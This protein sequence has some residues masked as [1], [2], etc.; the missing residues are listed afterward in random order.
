LSIIKLN[1][2]STSISF[3][4]ILMA[5]STYFKPD[6]NKDEK[7]VPSGKVYRQLFEAQVQLGKAYDKVKDKLVQQNPQIKVKRD[8][9]P[10]VKENSSLRG[11]GFLTNDAR[12]WINKLENDPY[13]NNPVYQK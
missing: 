4:L 5:T 8:G 12:D 6:L 10:L 3:P 7:S 13:S 1:L 2:N 11:H 9:I